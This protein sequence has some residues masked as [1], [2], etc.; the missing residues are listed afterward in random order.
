MFGKR[1]QSNRVPANEVIAKYE[2]IKEKANAIDDMEKRLQF[3][4]DELDKFDK[5]ELEIIAIFVHESK[6]L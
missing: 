3:L 2:V 4:R 5:R 1:V 6:S